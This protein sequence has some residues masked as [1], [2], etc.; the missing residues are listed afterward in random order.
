MTDSWC[1]MITMFETTT[2][3]T[4]WFGW[5][6]LNLNYDFFSFHSELRVWENF[7]GCS[8]WCHFGFVF[9]CS[10]CCYIFCCYFCFIIYRIWYSC[11]LSLNVDA[12]CCLLEC[13]VWFARVARISH[14]HNIGWLNL[15][16]RRVDCLTLD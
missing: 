12:R 4:T 6:L 2:W 9:S 1:E 13:G 15:I 7:L 5:T 11:W 16:G 10:C 8:C 3:L 14:K